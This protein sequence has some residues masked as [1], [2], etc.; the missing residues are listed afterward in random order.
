M[1]DLI[2]TEVGDLILGLPDVDKIVERDEVQFGEWKK[3]GVFPNWFITSLKTL[4]VG[5]S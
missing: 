1:D 4:S 3:S 5:K 2:P